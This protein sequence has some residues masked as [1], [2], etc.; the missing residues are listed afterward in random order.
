MKSKDKYPVAPEPMWGR[1]HVDVISGL[2]SLSPRAKKLCMVGLLYLMKN[3]HF[4][5][6]QVAAL[7]CGLTTESVEGLM[8]EIRT[9]G[10]HMYFP[11]GSEEL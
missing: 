1:K 11:C 2:Q 9:K 3:G 5:S 10:I 8:N 6:R 7:Q 4:P